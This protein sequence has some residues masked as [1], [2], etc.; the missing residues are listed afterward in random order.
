MIDEIL[1]FIVF[2]F[3]KM[4]LVECNYEIYDKKLLAIIK[5]F[6]KWRSKYV[7]TFV[8]NSMKIL[9]NHKNLKHFMTSKQFNCKQTRWAKFLSKFNFRII[10]R[11]EIQ[12][13]KSNNLTRRF[14]NFLKN[15]KN[16][17]IQFNHQ[18]LLKIKNFDSSIKKVIKM[19]LD[20][21]NEREKSV[22]QIIIMMYNL[23]EKKVFANEKS[24][25]KSFANNFE[26]SINEKSI[27]K[28][29]IEKLIDQLN[30]M[31]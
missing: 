20:L 16:E 15:I 3:K 1:R 25:E 22:I 21:M 5:V 30:I 26:T 13:I 8:K 27:E 11:L 31:Q 12:N 17:R 14:E 29:S 2:M 24:I 7:E 23:I 9:T 4:F 28:L 6:E 10:Y 19:T 18:T